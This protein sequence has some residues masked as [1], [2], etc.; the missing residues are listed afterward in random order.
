MDGAAALNPQLISAQER[1]FAVPAVAGIPGVYAPAFS[2]Q[3]MQSLESIVANIVADRMT[4]SG[5]GSGAGGSGGAGGGS[6]GSGNPVVIDPY[7][8][9]GNL[10]P[11]IR[12]I[13]GE[14]D[15]NYET[16]ALGRLVRFQTDDLRQTTR[17]GRL[18]H[19]QDTPGKLVG[20]HAGHL[21][22]DRFGGSPRLNNLV[23]QSSR[24]NLS[25]YKRLENKCARA[26]RDGKN[27][28]VDVSII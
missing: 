26:T 15:Y 19:I 28:S 2:Y 20:D 21:A 13:A 14:F 22:G 8:S 18:P 3:A 12:F 9:A 5:G 1:S 16:D 17:V 27:E 11:N 10:R 23:S 6:Q 7:D 4:I 24:V 25:L